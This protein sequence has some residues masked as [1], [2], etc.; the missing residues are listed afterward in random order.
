[1]RTKRG[2]GVV[3]VAIMGVAFAIPSVASQDKLKER[4]IN[5]YLKEAFGEAE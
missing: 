1:M 5:R 4:D 3:L 2:L